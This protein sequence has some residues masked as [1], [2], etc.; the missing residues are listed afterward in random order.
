MGGNKAR[1]KKNEMLKSLWKNTCTQDKKLK[2]MQ[3][4]QPLLFHKMWKEPITYCFYA[5][6]KM[7][8]A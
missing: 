3:L 1:L 7:S 8:E 6:A 5:R 2:L 4:V